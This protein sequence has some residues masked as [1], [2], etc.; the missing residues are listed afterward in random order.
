MGK[1]KQ[2]TVKNK[3]RYLEDLKT[4]KDLLVEVEENPLI[5]PWAFFTWGVLIIIGSILHVIIEYSF[6]LT[7]LKHIIFIWSP[8]IAIGGF[9]ECMGFIRKMS[10]DCMSLFSR[11]SKKLWTSLVAITIVFAI[12]IGI[13]LRT[14][15]TAYLPL[16]MLL[17]ISV[18]FLGF[19]L[20]AYSKMFIPAFFLIL[21]SILFFI[22]DFKVLMAVLVA[23]L[24]I[25]LSFIGIGI[26]VWR[27]EKRK[28]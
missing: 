9:F 7:G 14:A 6:N 21:I 23:G 25:G 17:Y 22:F 15:G 5:E 10:K 28:K 16:T 12:I 4:I 13:L 11:V 3:Q 8:I 24:L 19:G 20:I 18:C 26:M 1:E 27:D 2:K